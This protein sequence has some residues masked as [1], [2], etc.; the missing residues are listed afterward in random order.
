M[1][2]EVAAA[3]D[4][5]QSM[6]ARPLRDERKHGG[7]PLLVGRANQHGVE[8]TRPHQVVYFVGVRQGNEAT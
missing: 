3:L 4:D 8:L 7:R 2:A 6:Q 1:A 5:N